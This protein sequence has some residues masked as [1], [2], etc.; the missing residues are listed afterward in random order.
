MLTNRP[1]THFTSFDGNGNVEVLVNA[2]DATALA[3]YEYGP[4]GKSSGPPAPW[5]RPTPSGSS[6]KY[7]DDETDLFTTASDTT[8][9]RNVAIAI[10]T[11]GIRLWCLGSRSEPYLVA[12]SDDAI[13]RM[14]RLIRRSRAGGPN[15]YGLFARTHQLRKLT[16]LVWIAQFGE[17]P[18]QYLP[19]RRAHGTILQS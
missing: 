6:T 19:R 16:A 3:Q 9:N 18:A 4:F 17:H 11:R 13:E 10:L 15:L 8:F 1:S 14:N 2:A 7:Q 12:I 5:Q